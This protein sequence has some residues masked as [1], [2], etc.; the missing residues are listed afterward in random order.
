MLQTSKMANQ[1]PSWN[2]TFSGNVHCARIKLEIANG[3]CTIQKFTHFTAAIHLY[4]SHNASIVVPTGD[5][6]LLYACIINM[7]HRPRKTE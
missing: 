5:E 6:Y 3:L 2:D 4:F 7:V 1:C